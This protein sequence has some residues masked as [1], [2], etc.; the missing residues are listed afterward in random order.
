MHIR[1]NDVEELFQ[2]AQMMPQKS[3]SLTLRRRLAVAAF[4]ARVHTQ[5]VDSIL[6]IRLKV[7]MVTVI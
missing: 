6:Y 3:K 2:N 1:S 5:M 7:I 4:K